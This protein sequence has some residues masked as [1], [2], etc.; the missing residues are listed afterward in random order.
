MFEL[1]LFDDRDEAEAIY[2]RCMN[3]KKENVLYLRT[4]TFEEMITKY[5][6]NAILHHV[7][8]LWIISSNDEIKY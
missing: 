2:I 3:C 1:H 6:L 4:S 8:M 5:V 7:G